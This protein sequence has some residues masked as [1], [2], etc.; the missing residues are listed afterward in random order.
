[1][2]KRKRV[3][4]TSKKPPAVSVPADDKP[5]RTETLRYALIQKQKRDLTEQVAKERDRRF[6]D[7]VRATRQPT[8]PPGLLRQA[9]LPAG[10]PNQ[11]RILAEG[12]SWF[13]YPLP[14]PGGDGVIV[15]LEKQLGYSILNLAHHGDEVRQ[16]LGLNQRT[17]IIKRLSD[18]RIRF[19]AVLFSGGGNDLVGD[20][21]SL[22]LKHFMSPQTS[23]DELLSDSA[24]AAVLGVVEAGY[25]QLIEIRDRFCAQ[26]VLFFHGYD[27]PPVTGLGVCGAGPWLRPVLDDV[28]KSMGI[29]VP[30]PHQ[31]F[32]VVQALLKRFQALLKSIVT[33]PT[34]HNTVLIETQGTLVADNNDWQNE[35][36][37][38]PGGFVKIADRFRRAILSRFP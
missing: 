10:H 1:M 16:M 9:M 5:S 29:A 11:L 34:I 6:E 35:L 19:D 36:H 15:Q 13:E 32:F 21:M 28:Y 33:D 23:P 17:E 7:Y 4:A 18:P 2:A 27:F 12:D 25:R 22:W 38:S 37:P 3:S 14:W 20:Q 8:A 31:Q 24:V 30:D 26:T